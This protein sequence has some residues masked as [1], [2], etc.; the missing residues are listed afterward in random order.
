MLKHQK[1]KHK[2]L[3]ANIRHSVSRSAELPLLAKT[4]AHGF[5]QGIQNSQQRG[6]GIEFNQYR[7]Y[8]VG[9]PL[10]KID[11]KLYARS[12]RYFVREA[13][14]ESEVDIWFVLDSSRSMTQ[15]INYDYNNYP[16]KNAF[17]IKNKLDF[18]KLMIASMSFLANQ[19]DD[20]F[21]FMALSSHE[22]SFLPR[23][24]G[25][26]HWQRLLIDLNDLHDGKYF[27]PAHLLSNH[28]AKIDKPSLIFIVSDFYQNNQEIF[29]F[30]KKIDR[31]RSEVVALNL[32]SRS[33]KE[34]K[35]CDDKELVRFKDL[36]SNQEQLVSAKVIKKDYLKKLEAHEKNL[37]KEL[38][39]LGVDLSSIDCEEPI[40]E[41][42]MS[43]MQSR[44]RNTLSVSRYSSAH[45]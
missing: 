40:E 32:T 27:P 25:S 37:A 11:W 16:G 30:I 34:F 45:Y 26:K 20:E 5:L 15:K 36:E 17:P 19:Q 10:S 24:K 28:L 42:L 21:G 6:L 7:S 39:R 31:K 18:S 3:E 12:D 9:D 23:G 43:Y 13:E 35:F 38:L 29:D 41:T 1:K 44:S 2:I 33:E 14:K 8:E 22:L 4:I